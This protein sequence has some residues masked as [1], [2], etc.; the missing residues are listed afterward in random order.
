MGKEILINQLFAGSYLE[1]GENVGHE[2]INLFEADDGKDYLYITP[3]GVVHGYHDVEAVVFVRNIEA[4][5]TAEV[6]A[7]AVGVEKLTDEQRSDLSWLR[8]GGVPLPQIFRGNKW[9]K[10]EDD[11]TNATYFAKEVRVP[12]K[13]RQVVLTL[14]DARRDGA[15]FLDSNQKVLFNQG[16]RGYY[17]EDSN[18]IAHAQLIEMIH[19]DSLWRTKESS[20]KSRKLVADGS[21]ASRE[22][23]FLEVIKKENDELVF[24]NLLAYYFDYN[25]ATFSK[26][27]SKVLGI[28]GMELDFSVRREYKNI[29]IYVTSGSRSIVIENKI[30][31]GVNG[32]RGDGSTQ[33][34]KYF[35]TAKE[36]A[37][38]DSA[39]ACF[40]FAPDYSQNDLKRYLDANCFKDPELEELVGKPYAGVYK[41]VPYSLV[42]GFFAANTPSYI[43]DR[44]FPDFIRGMKRHTAGTEAELNLETM[45]SRF[46]ERIRR[47]VS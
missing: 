7:V 38:D 46:L 40:V 32:R 17:S 2:I 43:A 14:D 37:G 20:R 11:Y 35:K 10:E 45:R 13:G 47:S 23:S 34:D 21:S 42:Y 15:V 16:M 1:M 5:R 25:H 26:F 27:A 9:K 8:Y 6:V 36:E 33:L 28:R 44:C 12:A 22:P 29:D 4:R 18:P 31:S 24:S 41:L 3:S 30:K 19:D 39:I